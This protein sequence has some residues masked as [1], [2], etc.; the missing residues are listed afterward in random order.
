MMCLNVRIVA[1]NRGEKLKSALVTE[2]VNAADAVV[3]QL[4]Y[5]ARSRCRQRLER[6]CF[7]GRLPCLVALTRFREVQL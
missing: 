3:Q 4:G 7:I 5:D 2:S 1:R 6:T